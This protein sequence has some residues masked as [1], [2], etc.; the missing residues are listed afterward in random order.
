VPTVTATLTLADRNDWDAP[1]SA[2]RVRRPRLQGLVIC[3]TVGQRRNQ[4]TAATSRGATMEQ[5]TTAHRTMRRALAVAIAGATFGLAGAGAIASTDE[6]AAVTPCRA[7]EADLVRAAYAARQLEW[8]RPDLFEN[9]PGGAREGPT[10]G[11]AGGGRARASRTYGWPRSGPAG[12]KRSRQ[13]S[14]AERADD[15]T[16]APPPGFG[17]SGGTS[18]RGPTSTSSPSSTQRA[19]PGITA[20][21]LP[22]L[23][24]LD[25]KTGPTRPSSSRAK[26]CNVSRTRPAEGER[27][28]LPV[29]APSGAECRGGTCEPA[30]VA[31]MAL[32]RVCICR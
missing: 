14:C 30:S 2:S 4:P 28:Y 17:R 20:A 10:A 8:Q 21:R 25:A 27:P 15:A 13:L 7:N 12:S 18:E 23:K 16:R 6:P 5:P 11:P 24:Q 26:P 1:K 3:H 22:I 19:G 32:P 31:G 29:V 9:S